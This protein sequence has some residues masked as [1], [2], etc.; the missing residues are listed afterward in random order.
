MINKTI[1]FIGYVW[2][3]P[4]SS[5]AGSR[6]LQLIHFF[7]NLGAKVVF[8]S[9]AKQSVHVHNL[10][11]EGVQQKEIE[12]NNFNTNIDLKNL[13]KYT[14]IFTKKINFRKFEC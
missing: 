11:S 7:K 9:P 2:P 13:K 5:A 4:T 12:L 3:E 8:S 10:L 6:M 1:L 14:N